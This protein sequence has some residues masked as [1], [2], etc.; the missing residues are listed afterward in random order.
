MIVHRIPPSD[1][2]VDD[3]PVRLRY[4]RTDAELARSVRAQYAARRRDGMSPGVARMY[5]VGWAVAI[6]GCEAVAA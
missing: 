2:R 6:L 5:V 1:V 4:W 3:E